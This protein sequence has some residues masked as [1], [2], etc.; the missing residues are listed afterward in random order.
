MYLRRELLLE[1]R[2]R[3]ADE[4]RGP[5]PGAEDGDAGRFRRLPEHGR[6]VGVVRDDEARRPRARDGGDR[7]PS[8]GRVERGEVRDLAVAEDLHAVGM[9]LREVAG[10]G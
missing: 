4:V 10:E 1:P 7:G 8:A 3:G 9:E 6:G 5:E 2:R